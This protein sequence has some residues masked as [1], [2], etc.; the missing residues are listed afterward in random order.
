MSGMDGYPGDSRGD[1]LAVQ[2]AEFTAEQIAAAARIIA[3]YESESL[4]FLLMAWDN[5]LIATNYLGPIQQSY[6][7]QEGILYTFAPA[8]RPMQRESYVFQGI[9]RYQTADV[10][11]K[12]AGVISAADE[13]ALESLTIAPPNDADMI[14]WAEFYAASEP[15]FSVNHQLG[16]RED[17][18]DNTQLLI[19]ELAD[20]TRPYLYE[21]PNTI[22]VDEVLEQIKTLGELKTPAHFKDSA[23]RK[24]TRMLFAASMLRSDGN[25][26]S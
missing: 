14:N 22:T 4:P 24:R 15:E 3:T 10:A 21:R 12:V 23:N 5:L 6:W 1:E 19:I 26:A 25:N 11:I 7:V 16:M 17:I 2:R 13:Q 18:V 20:G 8:I 9:T